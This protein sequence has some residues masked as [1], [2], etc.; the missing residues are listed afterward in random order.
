MNSKILKS[1]DY[2]ITK[3]DSKAGLFALE[4]VF[5]IGIP[6]NKP[7]HI[8]FLKLSKN[9]CQMRMKNKRINHNHLGGIHACAI[10]T[11][12]EF[13]AGILLCKNFQMIKYRVIMK[14][15]SVEYKK[16]ART[17]ITSLSELSEMEIESILKQIALEDK[18]TILLKT[19]VKDAQG[20]EV[21]IISTNWQMKD[22]SKT[23]LK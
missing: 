20:D 22:W 13:S 1:I 2:M 19:S 23:H 9:E 3:S 5:K 17:D 18:A 21:A 8:N 14:D 16:Q 7:H 12:G 15:I 4:K 10:A 6:F 11:L